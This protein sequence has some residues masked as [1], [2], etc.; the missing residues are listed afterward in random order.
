LRRH[1]GVHARAGPYAC[2][3]AGW[4]YSRFFPAVHGY[5]ASIDHEILLGLK[6]HPDRTGIAM[7]RRSWGWNDDYLMQVRTGSTR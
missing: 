7:K 1:R 3:W 5:Y 2:Q 4:H 6:Q